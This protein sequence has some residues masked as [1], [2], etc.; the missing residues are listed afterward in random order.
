MNPPTKRR[1]L[2]LQDYLA[3]VLAADRAI[4]GRAITLVESHHPAHQETAHALLEALMPHTGRTHRVGVT[5][6]PG[7]GKSTFLEALGT[8]LADLGHRVAVLAIDP[9]SV[10]TGGS[11]L[12]DK[13]RMESLSRHPRAFVRPSPTSGTL[14]GVAARTREAM[15]VCE[16]AGFDIL[17][18]ETVGVGQSELTVAQLTD[19]FLALML[20]G[21]GD[22]LQ[23]IK[24][25]IMEVADLMVVNKADGDALLPAQRAAST[26]AAALHTLHHSAPP[27]AWQPR[28]LTCSALHNHN[29]AEVWA[30]V[31]AHR[32]HAQAS[33]A[34][35]ARRQQHQLHWFWASL[36]EQLRAAF[37]ARAPVQAALPELQRAVQD[38]TLSPTVAALRL[39]KL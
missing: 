22:E 39:L 29:I 8:H 26:L 23:G 33:G 15:L 37:L 28:V 32:A 30:A 21:A 17:F 1:Q 10:R 4:L 24:R 34:W 3:G 9:S 35:E 19:T 20:A 7:A 14:G 12:G 36:D 38:G 5:G 11:I 25:G 6:V 16:A 13:T 18:I 31:Q 2:S 27:D